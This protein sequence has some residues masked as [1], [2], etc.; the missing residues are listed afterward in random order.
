MVLGLEVGDWGGSGESVE[1]VVLVF[2]TAFASVVT[3]EEIPMHHFQMR[4]P[5][6]VGSGVPRICLHWAHSNEALVV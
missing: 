1:A 6:A 5:L 4:W 3:E 2:A